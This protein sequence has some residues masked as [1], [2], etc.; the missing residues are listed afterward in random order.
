[1]LIDTHAHLN[2]NAF[3]NDADETAK[4]ALEKNIWM[5]NVGS[6]YSTS[7]RA[8]LMAEKYSKEV[9]PHTKN[10][11]DKAGDKIISSSNNHNDFGVGVYAAI[12]LHPIHL[13]EQK[14]QEKVD[15][16]EEFEV[17]SRAEEFDAEKY[18]KLA[19]S[20]KVVAIGETGLD[21]F[22]SDGNKEQQKEALEKQIDLAAELNLPIII[23]CRKAY[24]DLIEILKD[25]KKYYGNK[26]R[27]V[28]HSY[29]GRLSQAKIITEELGFHLGFNGIITFARD[30]DKVLTGIGLEYFLLE[31][32]CP[33][34]TPIPFRGKRNEPAYVSYVA[35]K[36]AEIKEIS[37]EEVSK[38]TTEN[39]RKLFEI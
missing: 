35:Q 30:Y 4:R 3:K 28:V 14:W 38:T 25:K 19:E 27:G 8:V 9:Y 15:D 31:T 24:D 39:A 12:G 37:I 7:E 16:D 20:K 21:Y 29:L 1:M 10:I 5:I 34:L 2:F 17:I 23:H 18:R 36:I 33:Y 26:F 6:Q 11:L 22:H 32:D 13:T